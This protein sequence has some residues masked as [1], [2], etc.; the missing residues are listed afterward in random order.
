MKTK[1]IYGYNF[2]STANSKFSPEKLKLLNL[3][4]MMDS[5]KDQMVSSFPGDKLSTLPIQ[6]TSEIS[7]V[8]E[9]SHFAS[10]HLKIIR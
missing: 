1:W 2:T 7:T 10:A 5:K 8:E 3:F 6:G 4:T 9:R